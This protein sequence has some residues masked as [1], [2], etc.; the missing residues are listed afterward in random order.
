MY[1]LSVGNDFIISSKLLRNTHTYISDNKTAKQNLV[2]TKLE[3]KNY[4]DQKW[5]G[6]IIEHMV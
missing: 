5:E 1:N 6:N 3:I 4:M 2:I